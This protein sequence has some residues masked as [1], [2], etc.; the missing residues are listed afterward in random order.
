MPRLRADQIEENAAARDSQQ[1]EKKDRR[2]KHP[3]SRAN[4]APF[5]PGQSGNPSGKPGYDVAAYIARQVLENNAEGIYAALTKSA[6]TGNAYVFKELA[7]RGCGKL[8][9]KIQ[10]T[11]DAEITARLLAGRKRVNGDSGEPASTP[12]GGDQ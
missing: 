9:D 12:S 8:T 10:V 11:T 7:E 6:L 4:L 1:P 5:R 3:N 2:G